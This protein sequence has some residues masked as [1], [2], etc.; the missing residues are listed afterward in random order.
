M[1]PNSGSV[2]ARIVIAALVAGAVAG[3]FVWAVHMVKVVPLIQQAELY[4]V[5]TEADHGGEAHPEGLERA[6]YTL[7]ADL[8]TAAGFA[9]MLCGAFALGGREVDWQRGIVWGLAG[10]ATFTASTS[11]GMPPE[12]P[13]MVSGDLGARRLWWLATVA[14]TGGG[15]G[16]IFLARPALLRIAGLVPI[17]LP[18]LWGAPRAEIVDGPL[19]AELASQFATASLVTSGLFWMVL[20]GT[21]GYMYHRLGRE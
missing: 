8:V 9:F 2:F 17:L 16:L 4:E 13:G 3:L 7:L 15:L 5:A 14:S 1:S 19:P 10:F 11:L 21:A 12:L 6:L 20:G 18:H